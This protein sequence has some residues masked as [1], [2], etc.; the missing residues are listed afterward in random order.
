M[1][2]PVLILFDIDGTLLS[3]QRAG[4]HAMDKVTRDL[5][6]PEFQWDVDMAGRLDPSIYAQAAI[7]NGINDHQLHH[8]D[9][10]DRYLEMLESELRGNPDRTVVMPG[11]REILQRLARRADARGDIV[12]GLLTGNY[13][14]AAPIKLAAAGIDTAI[15]ALGAYGDDGPTRPDLTAVAMSRFAQRTNT[16]CDP[17]KVIIIGDT[18]HD[19]HC[20]KVHG[21][22]AVGVATGTST[23]HE[24]GNAGAD[25]VL[26]D[27]SDPTPLESLIS[28]AAQQI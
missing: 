13:R 7:A 15:F 20:A 17:R 24:L 3:T 12:L 28:R 11:I 21:C 2:H 5:F 22:L 27:L 1:S 18:P 19:V 26:E 10:H 4:L 16:A 25:L 8:D 6:G 23:T 9:F 14:R